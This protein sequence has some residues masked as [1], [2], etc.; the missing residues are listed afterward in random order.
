MTIQPIQ[1]TNV[2][3]PLQNTIMTA[4]RNT[5]TQ[6]QNTITILNIFNLTNQLMGIELEQLQK[7]VVLKVI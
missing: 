7:E 4:M 1:T 3:I 2:V 5:T 6:S